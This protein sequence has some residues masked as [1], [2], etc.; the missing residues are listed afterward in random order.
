MQDPREKMQ[1]DLKEAMRARD[2]QRTGV[3]RMAL[4]AIRQEEIDSQKTLSAEDATAILLREAKK[5]RESIAE[6]EKAGRD[7]L[8]ET[9]KAELAIL[10]S[11]LPQQ[12]SP[13]AIREMARQAI[14]ETG[15]A[16][17]KDVGQV[18]RVLMPR[19]KGQ[20]DGKVVNQIVRELLSGQ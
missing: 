3:I 12:L 10:E 19:V 1:A 9:E 5:R 4:N 16:T 14:A 6:A 13:D 17:P 8:V 15:A 7:D 18:M 11:Y 20:A 2:R